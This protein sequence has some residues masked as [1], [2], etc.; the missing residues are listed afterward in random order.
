MKRIHL[1]LV[2]AQPIPNLIPLRIADIK[3]DEVI[4]LTTKQMQTHADNLA[5]VAKNWKIES[6]QENIDDFDMEKIQSRLIDILI[7][8]DDAGNDVWLNVT[9][10]SKIMALSCYKVMNE[11]NKVIYVDTYNNRIL[12]ISD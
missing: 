6:R 11:N 5:I 7:R 1:L 8:E 9:G 12:F 10:G 2:S 4:L 3:P